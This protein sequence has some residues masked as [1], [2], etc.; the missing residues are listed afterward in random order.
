VVGYTV[1]CST[2]CSFTLCKLW[3]DILCSTRRSFTIWMLWP[4]ILCSMRRSFTI[5]K[6]W[7]D[8]LCSMRRSF[9]IWKLWSDTLCSTRRSFTIWKLRSYQL[10]LL[11]NFGMANFLG[12]LWLSKLHQTK[13]PKGF[14]IFFYFHYLTTKLVESKEMKW[15][16]LPPPPKKVL[17][18]CKV[19]KFFLSKNF[20]IW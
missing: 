15:V 19:Q 8:T 18:Y 17:K 13:E 12:C 11:L 10:T 6:L 20:L 16:L 9:T 2:R 7:S 3:S 14:W 5:W 4:D 1:L